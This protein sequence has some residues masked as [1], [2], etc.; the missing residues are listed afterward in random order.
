MDLLT[1]ILGLADRSRCGGSFN[2]TQ[3]KQ[4]TAR[5][6][7]ICGQLQWQS[8]DDAGRKELV[9]E[10]KTINSQL[11]QT[12]YEA[13]ARRLQERQ[14]RLLEQ[15]EKKKWERWRRESNAAALTAASHAKLLSADGT[16]KTY[17]RC[18]G[19]DTVADGRDWQSA[20][21]GGDAVERDLA[22]S[23]TLGIM[24]AD[25]SRRRRRQKAREAAAAER[26][27]KIKDRRHQDSS[28]YMA[29]EMQQRKRRKVID[30]YV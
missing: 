8:G 15:T 1:T 21:N 23:R 14:L 20:D 10:L 16:H 26:E 28:A 24:A 18:G 6:Q 2:A 5:L 25:A 27:N 3:P 22:D 9:R 13:Q 17:N 30:A 29:L 4:L 7:E 12:Q 19:V 11:Q